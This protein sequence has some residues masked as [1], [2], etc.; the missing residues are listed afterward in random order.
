MKN[1]FKKLMKS[2]AGEEVDPTAAFNESLEQLNKAVDGG[3]EV[4]AEETPAEE[5]ATEE[6]ST[7]EAPAEEPVEEPVNEEPV[8]EEAPAEEPAEEVNKSV[9][10]LESIIH[11][12]APEVAKTIEGT[13][14]LKSLVNAIDSKIDTIVSTIDGKI[15]PLAKSVE[16]VTEI[17]KALAKTVAAEGELLKSQ[18]EVDEASQEQP[19]IRKSQV[20]TMERFTKSENGE[21]TQITVVEAKNKLG[22]F[23]KSGVV[24]PMKVPVYEKML[25]RGQI[26]PELQKVIIDNAK[27]K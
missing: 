18:L 11:E 12:Q 27:V 1:L 3:E 23:A 6:V 17:T 10:S 24:S 9:A 14:F 5:P 21:E 4:P 20:M 15:N 13:E 19:E 2:E 7:E 26:H 25:N 8:S 22:E 16:G